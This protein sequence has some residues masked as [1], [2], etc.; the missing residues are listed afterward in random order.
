MTSVSNITR[1]YANLQSR[2]NQKQSGGAQA[3]A[4][5]P[6][7]EPGIFDNIFGGDKKAEPAV[8][9]KVEPES[10]SILEKLG[11]SLNKGLYQ[12]ELL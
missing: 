11:F 8:P 9:A 3:I 5:A 4:A 2:R 7:P 6:A 12:L 10:T 1:Q